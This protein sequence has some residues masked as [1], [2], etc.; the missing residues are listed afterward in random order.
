MRFAIRSFGRRPVFGLA[1]ILTIALGI[2]ANTALF[3]VI[4]TVLIQPLPFRDPGKL[5]QIWEKRVR[6]AI[7]AAPAELVRM[8]LREALVLTLPGIMVGAILSLAFAR[9]MKSFVY[10]LSPADPISIVSAS[11]RALVTQK[12]PAIG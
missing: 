11:R 6:A 3:G 12:N 1:V 9:V 10:R 2:G 8:I 7:G 4:Y 5:V